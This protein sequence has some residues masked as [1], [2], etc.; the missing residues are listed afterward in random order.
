MQMPLRSA[1]VAVACARTQTDREPRDVAA[2]RGKLHSPR[3]EWV[4]TAIGLFA[5]LSEYGCRRQRIGRPP[6]DEPVDRH[7]ALSNA[8]RKCPLSDE[9]KQHTGAGDARSHEARW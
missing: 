6:G 5:K 1:V 8:V 4:G 7:R 2:L 3:D 9:R